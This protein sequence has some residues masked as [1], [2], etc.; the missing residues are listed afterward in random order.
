VPSSRDGLVLGV[1]L[2]VLLALGGLGLFI[3]LLWIVRGV[4]QRRWRFAVTGCLVLVLLPLVLIPGTCFLQ[5]YSGGGPRAAVHRLSAALRPG[6]DAREIARLTTSTPVLARVS[7]RRCGYWWL[8]IRSVHP[9]L[10]AADIDG[11]ATHLKA[12]GDFTLIFLVY[13]SQF[14]M[15]VSLDESGRAR[16][17]S[18][19]RGHLQ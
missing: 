7:G 8:N 9:A 1:G 13:P 16:S 4:R 12:C 11:V 2:V 18:P 14:E 19:V 5:L 6:I 10:S 15:D 3:G 17:V